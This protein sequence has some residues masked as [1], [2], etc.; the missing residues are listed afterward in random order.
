[1]VHALSKRPVDARSCTCLQV[2]KCAIYVD[3]RLMAAAGHNTR[4]ISTTS[5]RCGIQMQRR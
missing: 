5:G 4:P 2:R 1:M 3:Q